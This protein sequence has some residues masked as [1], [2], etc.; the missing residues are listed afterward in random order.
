[1]AKGANEPPHPYQVRRASKVRRTCET[2]THPYA[3]CGSEKR[4]PGQE[5]RRE[6]GEGQVPRRRFQP[7]PKCALKNPALGPVLGARTAPE[8]GAWSEQ[9]VKRPP[10]A[11]G[12][13]KGWARAMPSPTDRPRDGGLERARC[14]ASNTA[15]RSSISRIRKGRLGQVKD[16]SGAG[17]R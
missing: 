17:M 5:T 10:V 6:R 14:Q 4:P 12:A 9:D 1:M 15:S 11:P 16:S 8:T 7:T 3:G 2:P 13:S